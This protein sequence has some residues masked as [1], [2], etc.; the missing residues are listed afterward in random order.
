MNYASGYH[1]LAQIIKGVPIQCMVL[2]SVSLGQVRVKPS[3]GYQREDIRI[4]GNRLGI[5][6]VNNRSKCESLIPAV[7]EEFECNEIFTPEMTMAR[8]FDSN[9]SLLQSNTRSFRPSCAR[10]RRA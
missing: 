9:V 10:S 1:E 2:P 4:S 8:I 5:L 3:V 6:D 7:K